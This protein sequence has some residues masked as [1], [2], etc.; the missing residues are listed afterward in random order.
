MTCWILL[1]PTS[2]QSK[3]DPVHLKVSFL[4]E[5]C[6]WGITR[7]LL[8]LAVIS[9]YQETHVYF[10]VFLLLVECIFYH[11]YSLPKGAIKYSHKLTCLNNRNLFSSSEYF[12][13]SSSLRQIQSVCSA[14]V[15][16]GHWEEICFSVFQLWKHPAMLV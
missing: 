3:T 5:R 16:L 14:T 11:L 8:I 12:L 7:Q 13:K 6:M 2:S 4:L 15:S 1:V 9:V 10:I